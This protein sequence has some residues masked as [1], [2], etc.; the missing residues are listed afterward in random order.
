MAEQ[1]IA[2]R[3]TDKLKAILDA[4]SVRQQFENALA[5]NAS[6]FAASILDLYSQDKALQACEPGAVVAEALKAATLKLPINKSLGYAWIVPYKERGKPKP[7]FQLGYKGMIQLAI[8]TGLYRHINADKIYEGEEVVKDRLTGEIAITGEPTTSKVIGYFAHIE[9]IN[10]FRKTV[11]W[12]R[13]QVIEHAKRF[14][15]SYKSKYSA[16]ATDFDAM[17]LKTVLRSLLSKYGIMSVEMVS[18]FAQDQEAEERRADEPMEGWFAE[19]DEG[20]VIDTENLAAGPQQE[21]PSPQTEEPP[22][23]DNREPE[24]IEMPHPKGQETLINEGPGF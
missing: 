20:Q 24:T 7:Q 12:T 19:Q 15:K 3:P 23:E 17:A 21:E 1:Q 8:R 10:G 18:A 11:C 6:L 9:L 4:P 2:K 14:S 16:W 13:E 5:E 22:S